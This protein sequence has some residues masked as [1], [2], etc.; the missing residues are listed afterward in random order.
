MGSMR[1]GSGNEFYVLF[2]KN[3]C[4][5][6]GFS[7]EHWQNDMP[8]H[9]FYESVPSMFSSAVK[10]PAFSPDYVS[11]CYWRAW[12]ASEWEYAKVPLPETDD[13]DGSKFLLAELDG[14]PASYKSFAEDYYE[15]LVPMEAVRHIYAHRALSQSL[16]HS[17]NPNLSLADLTTE[18]KEI[19]YPATT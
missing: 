5:L 14:D 9:Q 7:H 17:L 6:K 16:I 19:G 10:E 18:L 3:G 11:F 13:P 12:S 15:Q 4:Y 8:A 2:D 1:N